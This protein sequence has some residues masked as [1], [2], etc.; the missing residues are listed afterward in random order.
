MKGLSD[1]SLSFFRELI[2]RIPWLE[3]RSVIDP[4]P[5]VDEGSLLI[6][7]SPPPIREHSQFWVSTNE[8]EVTVGFGMFHM[9]FEWP[10][11][12]DQEFWEDPVDFILDLVEERVL[13]E[14]WTKNGK[15]SGSSI[16]KR[17]E[18]P[19]TSEM[20]EDNK[21]HIRSWTGVFDRTILC[22]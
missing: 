12:S 8:G 5:E 17:G 16:L 6:D 9:H 18:Q 19:D 7:F 13:I 21:I 3:S 4:H 1:F 15:W 10:C 20:D 2:R 22:K 11:P 14:D